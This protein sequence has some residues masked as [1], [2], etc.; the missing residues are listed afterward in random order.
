[1]STTSHSAPP[2][3][4]PRITS[5][6]SARVFPFTRGLPQKAVTRIRSAPYRNTWSDSI[7]ASACD[8]LDSNMGKGSRCLLPCFL[9]DGNNRGDNIGVGRP[10]VAKPRLGRDPPNH[11]RH[12]HQPFNGGWIPVCRIRGHGL[13]NASDTYGIGIA[14]AARCRTRQQSALHTLRTTFGQAVQYTCSSRPLRPD[15]IFG[16]RWNRPDTQEAHAAQDQ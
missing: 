4:A 15:R 14:A 5:S 13:H 9:I 7:T 1:M 8:H 16:G 6:T 10:E 11:R 12:A 3:P 2:L